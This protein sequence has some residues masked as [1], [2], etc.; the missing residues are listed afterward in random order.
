MRRAGR[1]ARPAIGLAVAGVFVWL[2]ASRV[3][4]TG[5]RRVLGAASPGPLV[6][7]L[8][9]LAADMAVRIVRW[10]WM[11]RA[12][13]P[14]LPPRRCVRP[15][16]AS[17]AL[18]NTLPLRA[19]DVVRAFGFR[20]ALRAPPGSVLGTLVIERVL[21]LLVLLA[22]FF[23]GL[24]GVASGVF[25]HGY[26]AVGAAAGA[27]AL[28][29][30]LVFV[31]APAAVLRRLRRLEARWSDHPLAG[32]VVRAAEHFVAALAAL[33]S[34][35][36]ALQ[37]LALSVLAWVLEG[38]V[39]AGVAWSLHVG[40]APLAPWFALATGTLATLVPGS[41]GYV[42][43]FDYFAMLG[44]TAYGADRN[45]AAA[46]A[47]LVHLVLWLPVTV[48]GGALLLAPAARLRRVR[49]QAEPA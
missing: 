16:L 39:Y 8:V 20:E 2:L 5:V 27:L 6:L 47:L 17:L 15:F 10:W 18:N 40:G 34:P 29:T 31:L 11:L 19:G 9:L 12:L 30:L 32:R 36:R 37:L 14:A 13:D 44:L 24:V 7:A 41:P 42:G 48:A 45:V 35:L 21:D 23:A 3:E 38:A 4:W 49:Q 22:I 43:T 25:P 33:Q 46:F 28:G 26:V 1:W